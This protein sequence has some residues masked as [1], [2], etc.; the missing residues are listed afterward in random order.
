MDKSRVRDRSLI[1]EGKI[2]HEDRFDFSELSA[3]PEVKRHFSSVI[4][5]FDGTLANSMWVWEDIDRKFI[6]YYDLVLPE[7][8]Y[9]DISSLSFEETA[10]FFQET[11][12]VKMSVRE[13]GDKFNDLAYE[14]YAHDVKL[15]KGVKKYLQ[16]LQ[17]RGCGIAIATSL[18][19]PLLEAALENNGVLSY[20]EDMAFCDESKGKNFPDVYMM[21]AKRIGAKAE[22]C[23]VFEDITPG[24]ISAKKIGMTVGG[25]IDDNYQQDVDG[26]KSNAD[27]CIEDFEILA[28]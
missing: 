23:L 19:W 18:S 4:F 6:E 14:S 10:V 9:E 26:V 16:K 28:R 5:D 11:L 7:S 15:K 13:I 22:D 20:F 24:I 27:F 17:S 2:H 8:Y 12:G 21:A 25:V 1:V 3:F